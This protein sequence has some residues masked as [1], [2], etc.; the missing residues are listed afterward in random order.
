VTFCHSAED[1]ISINVSIYISKKPR[2]HKQT[3]SQW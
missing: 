2:S 3:N 1:G